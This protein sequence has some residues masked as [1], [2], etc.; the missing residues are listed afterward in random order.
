MSFPFFNNV[1]HVYIQTSVRISHPGD[2]IAAIYGAQAAND[3]GWR[4]AVPVSQEA[5]AMRTANLNHLHAGLLG[6]PVLVADADS[7]F[8]AA[9]NAASHGTFCKG[10]QQ[11]LQPP[12]QASLTGRRCLPYFQGQQPKLS[13]CGLRHCSPHL[14]AGATTI[15]TTCA[16]AIDTWCVHSSL[17]T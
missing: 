5:L 3:H 15:D 11:V 7:D 1:Q 10:S 6:P 2:C 12:S 13:D 8:M 9:N 17:T 4:D 16:H 14:S